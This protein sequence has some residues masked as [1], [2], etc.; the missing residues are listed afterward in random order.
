MTSGSLKI[1]LLETRNKDKN[2]KSSKRGKKTHYT[3]KNTYKDDS[4]FSSLKTRQT[5]RK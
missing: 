1:K 5:R 4:K 3:E 2:S